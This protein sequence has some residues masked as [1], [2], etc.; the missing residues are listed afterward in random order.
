MMPRGF[1]HGFY[2]IHPAQKGFSLMTASDSKIF[3]GNRWMLTLSVLIAAAS[4]YLL[5]SFTND[6]WQISAQLQLI[7]VAFYLLIFWFCF[8]LSGRFNIAALLTLAIACLIG[9]ANYVVISF[10]G[11]PIVPWDFLSLNTA[12]T[13]NQNYQLQFSWRIWI[14]ALAA[15]IVIVVSLS[16]KVRLRNHL[17]RIVISAV[18]IVLLT[19]CLL[20]LHNP[21]FTQS[22]DFD[23]TLFTP[24][25][26][27]K[28][29]GFTASFL[30][31]LK[32][33]RIEQPQGYSDKRVS[34]L[35]D[36]I[37]ADI[38]E[39]PDITTDTGDWPNILVVMNEAFSDLSILADFETNQDYMPFVNS[40]EEN[41]VRGDLYVSVIGGNT[42]TTEF[43]FLTGGSM[44]FLPPGSIAY[45]QYILD[46]LSSLPSE[47]KKIGY[48]TQALHPYYPGGWDRDEVYEYLGFDEILFQNDFSYI[49][50]IRKYISDKSVYLQMIKAFEQK[51]EKTPLFS[52][53]V[54]MQN[55]GG[56]SEK[57]P[58]FT[59]DVKIIN[60]TGDFSRVEMYLSLIKESDQA[61]KQLVNYFT[62]VDEKTIILFFGDHQPHDQVVRSLMRL[63]QVR[64]DNST[65]EF[66]RYQVPFLIWA[67]YDINEQKELAISPNFLSSLLMK[68]AGIPRTDYN[69]FLSQIWQK[70]PVMT[71]DFFMNA[72][73]TLASYQKMTTE[74]KSLVNE[75]ATLQFNHL[76][77]NHSR[78]DYFFELP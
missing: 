52:F 9:F 31:N 20:T 57:Y 72:E 69:R 32:Y 48:Q 17:L 35:I 64:S 13:V 67:N 71:A 29:N 5:E 55:H 8:G 66:K 49:H 62:A 75:Y 34:E 30:F 28:Q 76:F 50:R 44:A 40:L 63:N 10:R 19:G 1:N 56:Y 45:Q 26:L 70:I 16:V 14:T 18:S 6:P 37:K 73:G 15:L 41:T 46:S 2:K 21:Q 43:E 58:D 12:L 11:T 24:V 3:Q 25:R 47:L 65:Y 4:F 77:A 74:Q 78:H 51:N 60:Q 7:N 23:D 33:L 54:T 53:A 59:P 39:N 42:A 27:Y 38:T 36:E 61:F 68:T 22:I